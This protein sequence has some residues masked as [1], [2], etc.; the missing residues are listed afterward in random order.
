MLRQKLAEKLI[1]AKSERER[2]ALLLE[3][4]TQADEKLA[5]ALKEICYAL[6]T[7]EPT[8]A[9]NASLVLQSL[10]KLNPADEI[11]ALSFWVSGISDITKGRL[12]SAV[13]NFDKSAETFLKINQEHEA[14]NTQVAKIFALAMLGKYDEAIKSGE[15]ALKIFEKYDDQLA[16]GKI[17]NNIGN[18]FIRQELLRR[19]EKYYLSARKRFSKLKNTEQLLL[20]EIG[21]AN[22]YSALND[23]RKAE[24]YYKKTLSRAEESKMLVRQAEIETNIGNLAKFRGK[25]DEAL[26]YLEFSRQKYE[27]LKMLPQS[28]IAELEIA[29]IYLE[30]NLVKEAFSIY[31]EVSEKLCELKLQGEEAR[32]RANFGRTAAILNEAKLAQ[33]ELKNAA[34]L[35]VAEKNQVG[36]TAV[37]LSEANLKLN[38]KNY[39]GALK[40]IREAQKLIAKS[41]N[42]R[43]KLSADWLEGETLGILGKFQKAKNLLEKTYAE[44]IKQEQPNIAQLSQNSLG[45]LHLQAGDA[46]K[47]KKH[48]K[49]A[50]EL[51]EKLRTPLPGEEFRMAFLADKLAPFENLAKIYATEN[52]LKKAFWFVEKARARSLAENLDNEP[53]EAEISDKLG[54]KLQKLR[55]ELNWFYSRLDF[56]EETEIENLQREAKL[57][58]KQIADVMRQ[59]ESTKIAQDGAIYADLSDKSANAEFKELQNLLGKQ[60]ALIEF[61]NFDGNLSA[62]VVTDKKNHF[63]ANLATEDEILSLLENLQFQFGALRYG[64]KILDKFLGELKKRA[65]FYLQKLYEKLLKPLESFIEQR[66]LVIVPVGVLHYVPFH[67]LR[68]GENYVIENREVIYAPS[69]NVWRKLAAKPARKLDNALLIGFADERIPLVNNEIKALEKIFKASKSFTKSKATFAAFTKNAANFDVL[70]LACHGQFRSENPLF[71][72]L[73]LADGWITVRDVCSQ[74]LK[75]EV[76]TLSACETGLNKIFAG[77]EIL[78]LAR[79]FL[80][81]GANSLILSLW[82]V[83]DEATVRLMKI[84]YTELQSGK[85]VS[86]ALRK[87]QC[88]FIAQN[89]HPYFWSPFISVGN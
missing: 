59:I 31:E 19:A 47:A 87:A 44:A 20:S 33:K 89:I 2:S 61:V 8:K 12:E 43:H 24:T 45:K 80:S 49:K 55:E 79:G 77:D 13:E 69:A 27:I 63:F 53:P 86:A 16:A 18:I 48:F 9:Q 41:D 21:L 29:D 7:S 40:S 28:A 52:D 66:D 39:E 85:R 50:V 37:K 62:F 22:T 54:R 57:R 32:A 58:E 65:D 74:K 88:N 60:K 6:W 30:L 67:A 34:R 72:S 15:K 1:S 38:S 42:T 25:Y 14:A 3:N 76:V 73:H 70:H 83:N 64:G 82:T 11:K 46:S 75:A 23:F 56:A 71:S 81:A 51:I 68:G 4:K 26:K 36:A 78:G 84:F 10:I 17:E 35:Y 5:I